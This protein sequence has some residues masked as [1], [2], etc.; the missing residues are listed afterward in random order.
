MPAPKRFDSPIYLAKISAV[1]LFAHLSAPVSLAQTE[2]G[3]NDAQDNTK[4]LEEITVEGQ[5]FEKRQPLPKGNFVFSP[6]LVTRVN[7][8]SGRAALH[9]FYE[10]IF[11]PVIVND[12]GYLEFDADPRRER[13]S[14][15]PQ[16]RDKRP[17]TGTHIKRIPPSFYKFT[18]EE[19]LY[20][21]TQINY[22]IQTRPTI[23]NDPTQPSAIIDFE[24]E[25]SLDDFRYCLSEGTL[26]FDVQKDTTATFGKLII[27]GLGRVRHD[28]DFENHAPIVAVEAPTTRPADGHLFAKDPNPVAWGVGHFD[29]NSKMCQSGDH[30]VTSGWPI[31]KEWVW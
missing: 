30:F 11:D 24:I 2:T 28:Y 31:S 8:E 26:V 14:I 18:L 16:L 19:G 1:C 3:Q 7:G 25:A 29:P 10:L 15:K 9:S 4:T 23:I 21:L 27:R 13:K 20:A 6:K 5:Q 17:R 12:N 22:R